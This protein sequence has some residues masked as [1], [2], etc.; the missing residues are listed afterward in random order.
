LNAEANAYRKQIQS[1]IKHQ[2]EQEG[3]LQ[4][5]KHELSLNTAAYNKM[6]D[7]EKNTIKGSMLHDQI[8][9]TTQQLNDAE[10]ALGNHRRS[11][12]DLR[13]KPFPH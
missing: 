4:K 5:L 6:S 8:E 3:S 12:G 7:V 2:N 13:S 11:V 10:N 9:K 1:T